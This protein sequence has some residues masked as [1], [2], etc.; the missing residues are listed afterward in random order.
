MPAKVSHILCSK[1]WI[2]NYGVNYNHFKTFYRYLT[3]IECNATQEINTKSGVTLGHRP[4]MC[5]K[6]VDAFRV[7]DGQT[8]IDMT[9][10]SGGHT[11][12][13]LATNKKIKVLA[14]DRDPIAYQRAV[15][16]AKNELIAA[17]GQQVIPLLG[18]FSELPNL[19]AT[20]DVEPDSVDGVIMDLGASSMQFDDPRRGFALSTDGPL[21][22][23]MDGKRFEM[24]PTA[25]DVVNTLSAEHLAKIF[26]IY[27]EE[28]Y[29][30]KIA[31]TIVDSR[32]LMRRLSSTTELAQ[33]IA[34]ITANYQSFDSLGRTQHSATKVFQA[35]RI[36][37]NNEINELNYVLQKV[38]TYLK[39]TLNLNFKKRDTEDN[40]YEDIDGGI[41]A[42]LSF[43]SLEDKIVKKHLIGTEVN[44]KFDVKHFNHLVVHNEQQ[45][46]EVLQKSW[47]Q[48]N[49][50]VITPNEDEV[51]ANPRSR[52]AKLRLAVKIS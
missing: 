34:N 50:R 51:V 17:N 2:N 46:D 5:R 6:I 45:L 31:Q 27:G 28:R 12:Y 22:M 42:V 52:S 3:A 29:A 26:K 9:F 1:H 7:K 8:Y 38:I 18:R 19:M 43:H 37:V 4:V 48:I 25:A 14:M 11:K 39:P 20:N 44:P 33:L 47:K 10:G 41:I 24:M 36:F 15:V 21:D 40:N 35:L 49:K 13:L 23:R 30:V 32:F 16:L